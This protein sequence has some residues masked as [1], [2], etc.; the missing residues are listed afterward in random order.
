MLTFIA[1]LL[2]YLTAF[3]EYHGMNASAWASGLVATALVIVRILA[4]IMLQ[5]TGKRFYAWAK[6]ENTRLGRA[7]LFVLHY[8]KDHPGHH[9]GCQSCSG[10]VAA[11]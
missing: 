7:V 3:L 5:P 2:G 9:K 10:T 6:Q 8:A 1:Y 4:S 11:S